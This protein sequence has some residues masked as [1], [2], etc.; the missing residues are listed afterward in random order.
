MTCRDA[1]AAGTCVAQGPA[2][3]GRHTGVAGDG[4]LTRREHKFMEG[5]NYPFINECERVA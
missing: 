5:T 1:V 3:Y 4:Q 2:G